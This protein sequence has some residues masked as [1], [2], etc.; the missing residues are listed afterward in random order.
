MWDLKIGANIA[1]K[2]GQE[3][4]RKGKANGRV[5]YRLNRRRVT[6]RI[7]RGLSRVLR[8]TAKPSSPIYRRALASWRLRFVPRPCVRSFY[9]PPEICKL[10]FTEKV[11]GT[12]LARRPARFLSPSLSTSPSSVTFP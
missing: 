4:P 1:G 2:K 3:I 6:K 10:F 7:L 12:L 8:R 9:L 11:F 5:L